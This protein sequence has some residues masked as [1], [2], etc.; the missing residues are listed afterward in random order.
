M[1]V[2]RIWQYQR[3]FPVSSEWSTRAPLVHRLG[4]LLVDHSPVQ[5][6]KY[7]LDSVLPVY[8]IYLVLS[9][10]AGEKGKRGIVQSTRSGI[11]SLHNLHINI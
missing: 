10:L 8:V 2:G 6:T 3:D 1:R 4:S 7:C 9:L 5:C 11:V